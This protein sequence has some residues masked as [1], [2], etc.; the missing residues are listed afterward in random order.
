MF[1]YYIFNFLSILYSALN[2]LTVKIKNLNVDFYD[3][4]Y[5]SRE[6]IDGLTGIFYTYQELINDCR[7]V[8]S[9]KSKKLNK[10]VLFLML[11]VV[12]FCVYVNLF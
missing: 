8:N 1:L 5:L 12:V 10:S 6:K 2:I 7:R 11:C 3:N 9:I 4:T